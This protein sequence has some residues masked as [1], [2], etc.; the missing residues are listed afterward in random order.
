MDEAIARMRERAERV[1]QEKYIFGDGSDYRK[2]FSGWGKRSAALA[3]AIGP[4]ERWTLHDTRR[5]VAT[6]LQEWTD[7]LTIEDL[8]GHTTG[9]RGGM[10]GVYNRAETLGRQRPALREWAI[11]LAGLT[12]S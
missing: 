3:K 11:L 7:P 8:L 9:V 12:K 6:R 4:S 2:P 10:A 1:G 5:T